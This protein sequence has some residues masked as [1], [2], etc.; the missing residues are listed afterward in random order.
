[1]SWCLSAVFD[2][3]GHSASLIGVYECVYN[4]Q[5]MSYLCTCLTHTNIYIH[6]DIDPIHS[7]KSPSDDDVDDDD[8]D[9]DLDEHNM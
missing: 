3:V 7:K 5:L 8:L 1:M 6:I 2:I 9:S 4:F